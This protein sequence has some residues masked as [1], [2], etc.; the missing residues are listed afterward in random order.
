MVLKLKCQKK[1][2]KNLL[3]KMNDAE[4][5][6]KFAEMQN[7]VEI[8]EVVKELFEKNKLFMITDLKRD[9]IKLLTRIYGIAKLKGLKE[10]ETLCEIYAQL[11]LSNERKSR[12]EILEAI[13]GHSQNMSFLSRMNPFSRNKQDMRY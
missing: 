7:K 6:N 3:I 12:K 4:I 13:R 10:W 8:A 5:M 11:V 9:E 2:F 1:R